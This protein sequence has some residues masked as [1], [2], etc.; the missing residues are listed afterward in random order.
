MLLDPRQIECFIAVAEERNL[1]RAATRLHMTQPPLTRRIAR[2]E[3]DLDAKLFRRTAGG[4]ELTE[5]GTVLLERAY[6]IVAL[7][8]GTVERTRLAK[9]GEIGHLAVGYYDTAVLEGVP[10][11]LAEFVDKY[12]GVTVSIERVHR[13]AQIDN[14]RDKV[15]HVGFGRHYPYQNDITCRTVLEEELYVACRNTTTIRGRASLTVDDLRGYPLVVYPR[16][17]PGFADEIIDLCIRSGFAPTV[18]VEAEDVIACLAHVAVGAAIAVVPRSAT[19]IR[20]RNVDYVP[21][22]DAKP[23]SLSCVYLTEHTSPGLRLFDTFL[24]D[25]DKEKL[26]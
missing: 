21:L 7:S 16:E 25:R 3:R 12:P 22:R 9:S 10:M 23:T 4:V 13:Q 17:R 20:P 11:V 2:L 14:L 1:N 15:L 18:A 5:P 19:S 8:Q 26:G 6:R 24:A